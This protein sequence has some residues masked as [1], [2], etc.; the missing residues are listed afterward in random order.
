MKKINF[1]KTALALGVSIGII[2][3]VTFLMIYVNGKYLNAEAWLSY[4]ATL[5][6]TFISGAVTFF[7]L[8]ITI[9]Q[10][11]D[12]Q[13][14]NLIN[15][16][17]PVLTIKYCSEDNFDETYYLNY[18]DNPYSEPDIIRMKI[19]NIGTGPAMDIRINF[20]KFKAVTNLFT[21]A[22]FNLGIGEEINLCIKGK[23]DTLLDSYS[24][25]QYISCIILCHDIFNKRNYKYD[26]TA[27][28]AKNSS[29]IEVF[30]INN[31][32]ISK[33]DCNDGGSK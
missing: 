14:E 24:L 3:F 18:M 9:K 21:Y 28:K 4:T 22:K 12:E 16:A 31:L 1:K 7:V 8:Y 19:K 6:G 29:N 23:L 27:I 2:I 5:L 17:R 33:C 32:S 30:E 26:I 20:D 25:D 11:H 10:N 15:G 13:E